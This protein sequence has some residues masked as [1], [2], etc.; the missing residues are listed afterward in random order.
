MLAPPA[1]G[2]AP[3]SIPFSSSVYDVLTP[4]CSHWLAATEGEELSLETLNQHEKLVLANYITMVTTSESNH[5]DAVLFSHWGGTPY[6]V[7]LLLL[8]GNTLLLRWSGLPSARW[9]G[10]WAGRCWE[11]GEE[12]HEEETKP[13]QNRCCHHGDASTGLPPTRTSI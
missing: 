10:P 12:L 6:G 9:A 8:L 13:D 4:S 7:D 5:T 3:K 2:G 1:E 11:E